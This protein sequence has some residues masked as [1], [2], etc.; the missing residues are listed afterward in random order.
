MLIQDLDYLKTRIAA[1]VKRVK[2]K[3]KVYMMLFSE[4]VERLNFRIQ[5]KESDSKQ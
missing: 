2:K 3:T 1:E 4:I 5:V